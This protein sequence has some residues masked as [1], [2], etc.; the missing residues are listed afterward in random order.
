[1][2]SIHHAAP[3]TLCRSALET[4]VACSKYSSLEQRLPSVALSSEKI[5]MQQQ[6]LCLQSG[7][8]PA[9]S[10]PHLRGQRLPEVVMKIEQVFSL[11]FLG[12]TW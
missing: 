3:P 12:A 1:V 4:Q 5:Q 2:S 6:D 7:T 9:P 8:H 11:S 10:F